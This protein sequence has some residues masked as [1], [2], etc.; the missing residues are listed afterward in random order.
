MDPITAVGAVA[1][2]IQLTQFSFNAIFKTTKFLKD[3][4]S[5]PQRIGELL[6]DTDR[7]VSRMM[8]LKLSLKNVNSK[9]PQRLTPDQLIALDTSI[10]HG[11]KAAESLTALLEPIFKSKATQS[12]RKLMWK[13]VISKTIESDVEEHLDKIQRHNDTIMKELQL[14][15]LDLQLQM[16]DELEQASI[17]AKEIISHEQVTLS[18]LKDLQM[19][20][21]GEALKTDN[22]AHAV[23]CLRSESNIIGTTVQHTNSEVQSLRETVVSQQKEALT[24]ISS[25]I[26][27]DS[28]SMQLQ[29]MRLRDDILPLLIGQQTSFSELMNREESLKLAE[30][31]REGLLAELRK[32]LVKHPSTMREACNFQ[33]AQLESSSVPLGME[34]PC[35][36][37]SHRNTKSA[38]FGFLSFHYETRDSHSPTCQEKY[39][40]STSQKFRLALQLL[41]FLN[42]TVELT[43]GATFYGGGFHIDPPLHLFATVQRSRS[44]MFRLFDSFP[45]SCNAVTKGS[46]KQDN[47]WSTP[48]TSFNRYE[49]DVEQARLQLQLLYRSLLD[50]ERNGLGS[51]QDRDENGHTVL[52]EMLILIGILAPIYASLVSE[53]DCL[54]HMTERAGV[55]VG[56]IANSSQS[57]R[58]LT[59]NEIVQ[60]NV[61]HSFGN[62]T[63]SVAARKIAKMFHRQFQS[64]AFLGRLSKFCHM[65]FEEFHK[66]PGKKPESEYRVPDEGTLPCDIRASLIECLV[67]EPWLTEYFYDDELSLVLLGRRLEKLE[68]LL[69]MLNLNSRNLGILPLNALDLACGW[70]EGLQLL[71]TVWKDD[72]AKTVNLMATAGEFESLLVLC[73]FPVPLFKNFA[74]MDDYMTPL[75]RNGTVLLDALWQRRNSL[76]EFARKRLPASDLIRFKLDDERRVLDAQASA[77]FHLLKERDFDVPSHLHP[78]PPGSV[79]GHAAAVFAGNHVGVPTWNS[80]LALDNF[81]DWGFRDLDDEQE[82]QDGLVSSPLECILGELRI[83]N[84]IWAPICAWFLRLGASPSFAGARRVKNILVGVAAALGQYEED[85]FLEL[86]E[87]RPTV[88]LFNYAVALFSP[89]ETDDCRCFCSSDGCQPLHHLLRGPLWAGK[90]RCHEHQGFRIWSWMRSCEMPDI[91][92]ELSLEEAVRIE[93]FNRLEM[94]HTCCRGQWSMSSE[95]RYKIWTKEEEKKMQLELIIS[96]YIKSRD[97]FSSY[98]LATG[99][100]S[101]CD[102]LE[103]ERTWPRYFYS[104]TGL[105]LHWCEWWSKAIKILPIDMTLEDAPTQ[106]CLRERF[107][108]IRAR[109]LR[110]Q[111]Y[112][113]MEFAAIVQ[114]HFEEELKKEEC[115]EYREAREPFLAKQLPLYLDL[116]LLHSCLDNGREPWDWLSI[117]LASSDE[118]L[119]EIKGQ[120]SEKDE[121]DSGDISEKNSAPK[122]VGELSDEL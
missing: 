33:V 71:S 89:L 40:R 21:E 104:V 36:C 52:H 26:R 86:H 8:N 122:V 15:G 62:W 93:V 6:S 101:A 30:Q 16:A 23:H 114:H 34:A 49:W 117:R 31:N 98:A 74:E 9:L 53:V 39:M 44:Y 61:W 47:M 95:E 37:R 77:V 17:A 20:I 88:A 54:L 11:L 10:D 80:L 48:G 42:R 70:P 91:E 56:A 1:A 5:Q 109:I 113:N 106:L 46:E 85:E 100:V 2:S 35:H 12:K 119:Q 107:A 32:E 41:P 38:T 3:L 18:K 94:T 51:L 67:R 110:Q 92:R 78:G 76:T 83:K 97:S 58:M 63:V 55:D 50:M 99:M 59:P 75:F 25:T 60:V 65:D 79:Y 22:L 27:N 72:I 105:H 66:G 28:S 90:R 112:G 103:E 81:Y 87:D 82:D 24:Q 96:S 120:A 19:N 57:S 73:N 108:E 116:A 69:P 4:A 29:I 111:G 84:P 13:M 43:F 14:S 115:A 45:E 7:S 121:N 118:A 102:C 64:F 68:A